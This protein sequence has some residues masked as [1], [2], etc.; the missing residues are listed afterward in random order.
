MDSVSWGRGGGE[1]RR[2]VFGPLEVPRGS[3]A[4]PGKG[5]RVFSSVEAFLAATL[6][7]SKD[8][9]FHESASLL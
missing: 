6:K 7:Q 9:N 2:G 8:A 1:I 3:R 4:D 5:T